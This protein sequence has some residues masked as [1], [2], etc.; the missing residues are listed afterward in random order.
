M[1]LT[2][3]DCI[4]IRL[5]TYGGLYVW[6]FEKRGRALNVRTDDSRPPHSRCWLMRLDTGP[7]NEPG[8]CCHSRYST[9]SLSLLADAIIAA[10]AM[11]AE[12]EMIV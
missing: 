3:H 10:F 6:E 7:D 8:H 12:I 1:P 4:N 5:P 9:V 2:A 11:D